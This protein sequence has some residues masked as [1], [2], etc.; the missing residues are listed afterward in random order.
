MIKVIFYRYTVPIVN[1]KGASGYITS[2][3]YPNNYINMDLREYY[4][5]APSIFYTVRI[6]TTIL[7]FRKIIYW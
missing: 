2:P 1:K 5:K 7:K 3:N 6:F 4:I